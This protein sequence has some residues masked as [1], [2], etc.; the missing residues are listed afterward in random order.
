MFIKHVA[1]VPTDHAMSTSPFFLCWNLP[2][3]QLRRRS[4]IAL[5]FA[6]VSL[7]ESADDKKHGLLYTGK[8]STF[9]PTLCKVTTTLFECLLLKVVTRERAPVADRDSRYL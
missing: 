3:L 5:N 2:R 8:G 9:N 7:V 6:D 1:V 4:Q